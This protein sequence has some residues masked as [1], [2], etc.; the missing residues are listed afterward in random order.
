MSSCHTR[1]RCPVRS[2]AV[3]RCAVVFHAR[4]FLILLYGICSS[5]VPCKSTAVRDLQLCHIVS[6]QVHLVKCRVWYCVIYGSVLSSYQVRYQVCDLYSS[7][8]VLQHCCTALSIIPLRMRL[9]AVLHTQKRRW[10]E[11][12]DSRVQTSLQYSNISCSDR[13]C[14][15][16]LYYN[17]NIKRSLRYRP[18][19]GTVLH[20]VSDVRPVWYI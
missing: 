16:R 5:V 10:R 14:K 1:L 19:H 13:Y 7:Y 11:D 20:Q 12:V 17:G 4:Y 3:L 18:C 2:C 8:Q 6:Y 15:T 9:P